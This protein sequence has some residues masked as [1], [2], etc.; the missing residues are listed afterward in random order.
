[1]TFEQ[2]TQQVMDTLEYR[3]NKK[4]FNAQKLLNN[5]E[6]TIS[7]ISDMLGFSDVSYFSKIFKN[8]TGKTPKQFQNY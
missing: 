8:K 5:G 1:M 7:Q 3:L 6:Y 4:I 2:F